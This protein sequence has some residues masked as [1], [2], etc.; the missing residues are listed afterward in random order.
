MNI[1]VI[2]SINMDYVLK[3]ADLPQ[4]GETVISTSFH[5]TGGGKGANQAVAARRL[6][7]EVYMIGALGNDSMGKELSLKLEN[8]GINI[9]GIKYVG[10]PTG[11]AMITVDE[12]GNNTIVVYPG[13]NAELDEKW[14]IKHE[15]IISKADFVV[16]Q[17]EIPM[18]TV[19]AAVKLA[20]KHNRK[21]ILNPAPAKEIPS[22]I[23]KYVDIITPNETELAALT[24]VSD[25]REG[26]K[27]LLSRGA[28]SVVVTIGEKGCYYIDENTEKLV[29]GIKVDAKDTTAAGDSFNG[30]LAVALSEGKSIGEALRFSNIVGALTATKIG[31]QDSLPHRKT[32]DEE[33]AK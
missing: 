8:E 24:G 22:E 20:K 31:A 9:A 19:E 21:V 12:A 14:I 29:E 5:V 32:V 2:G 11:N 15:D 7:A 17:L 3:V 16:L 10:V 18:N 26:A 25:V 1:V 23:Y 6:G 30:A 4:K 28:G 33:L 13:S 27:I